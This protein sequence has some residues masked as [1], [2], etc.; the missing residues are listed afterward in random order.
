MDCPCQPVKDYDKCC[1]RF[2]SHQLQAGNAQLLMRSRYSAYVLQKTDYILDTWHPD[3]RPEN[4]YIDD[5]LCWL[6]LD[7]LNFKEKGD[8]ATVEFE[9]RLLNGAKVN[10]LHEKSHFVREQERWFYTRGEMMTP[11]FKPWKPSKNETCPCGSGLKFKRCCA[12]RVKD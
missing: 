8:E 6:R 9:A 7:I 11:T 3:L 2:I 12:K 4:L 1:G 10:A 5:S